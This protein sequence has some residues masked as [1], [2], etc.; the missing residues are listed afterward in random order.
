MYFSI[1]KNPHRQNIPF[2]LRASFIKFKFSDQITETTVTAANLD[3][4]H[5]DLNPQWQNYSH[6]KINFK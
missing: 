2:K 6:E 3:M 5:M 1:C 4:G